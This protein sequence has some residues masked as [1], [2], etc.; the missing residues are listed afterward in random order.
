MKSQSTSE[1]V[2][3]LQ[4]T[5]KC[6]PLEIAKYFFDCYLHE[7]PL[8]LV[9][10]RD[11]YL[12]EFLKEHEELN[13]AWELVHENLYQAACIADDIK[14]TN[15]VGMGQLMLPQGYGA[16]EIAKYFRDVFDYDPSSK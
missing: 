16:A 13:E 4:K 7:N 10:L 1:L 3:T 9:K 6:K 8:G 11:A 2:R 15:H 5:K 12:H 14:R